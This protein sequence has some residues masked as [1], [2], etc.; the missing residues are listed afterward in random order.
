MADEKNI[1]KKE[2]NMVEAKTEEKTPPAK[3][4]IS[5]EEKARIKAEKVKMVKKKMEVL[6]AKKVKKAVKK[7]KTEEKE[8]KPVLSGLV[9]DLLPNWT[10]LNAKE[11]ASE[12][13]IYSM[14][15][16]AKDK[17]TLPAT[18][19]VVFR[20]DLIRKDVTAARAN[21]RQVYGPNERAGQK[22]SV[23]TWG[24]GHGV[25]RCQRI[26]GQRTGAQSP[27]NVGGRRAHP[28]N[29]DTVWSKKVNKKERVLAK[30]SALSATKERDVVT[31]RGHK[32]KEKITL[33]VV[34]EDGFK[35][36]NET[37]EVARVLENLGVIEDVERARNGT[38][39]RAGR[40][41]MRGRKYKTPKSILV[42]VDE[43]AP[44]I[45]AARNLPGVDVTTAACLSTEMLAP[46]GDPG[47]LT[48]FTK[49]A[50]KRLEG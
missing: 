25:A 11:A 14:E 35:D 36:I 40:G 48:I 27:C 50:I 41:K 38:H 47:R 33:P 4:D 26:K 15:G 34:V 42:V 22:H 31:A 5:P 29:T 23:E 16:K 30:L 45:F 2:E 37:A 12:I 9:K 46:G 44:V 3:L 20:P 19:F 39:I 1:E 6:K 21:R 17:M 28:P 10:D 43:D 49:S 7:V 32:F 18:F 24:K 8:L 13:N